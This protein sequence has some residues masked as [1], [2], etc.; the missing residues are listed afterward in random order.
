MWAAGFGIIHQSDV[1]AAIDD[2]VTLPSFTR[3]DA[4]VYWTLNETLRAQL[5]VENLFGTKYYATADGNNNI[6]PGSPTAVRVMV[7]TNF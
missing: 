7:T 3:A 4:A 5:N 2:T 1:F 6:T